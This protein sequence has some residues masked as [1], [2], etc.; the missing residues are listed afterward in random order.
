MAAYGGIGVYFGSNLLYRTLP[1]ASSREMTVVSRN[2]SLRSK[3]IFCANHFGID[4][5]PCIFG[6]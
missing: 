6:S 4:V 5:F 3:K 2:S 1:N